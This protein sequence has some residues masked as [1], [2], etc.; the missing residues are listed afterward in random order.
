MNKKYKISS[1][2]M[3]TLIKNIYEL[4]KKLSG[5]ITVKN[6]DNAAEL[7]VNLFGYK[8]WKEFK[9]NLKKEVM[10]E[11][12]DQ[13]ENDL[14]Q[15]NYLPK[16]DKV[17]N[18]NNLSKYTFYPKKIENVEKKQSNKYS[19]EYL[20]GS[21]LIPNMKTKQPRGLMATDCI[22]TGNYNEEY[23]NFIEKHIEW[24]IE[25]QQDFIVFSKNYI[26][27]RKYPNNVVM[28]GKDHV[29]LNPLKAILNTDMFDS[30]F[31]I[32]NAPKSFS[33]LWSF[34]VKK[35]DMEDKNLSI[36]DLVN[37][38]DLEKLLS[39]KNECKNDF[40]LEKMLSQY[41]MQYVTD[42]ESNMV[43]TTESELRHYKENVYLI[44][45]LKKIK[46][47]YDEGYFSEDTDFN[48]K[49]S[50]FQKQS[51]IIKDFEDSVYHELIMSE[52]IIAHK[53]FQSDKQITENQHLLWVLVIEAESWIKKYQTQLFKNHLSFA[54]CFYIQ[55]NTQHVDDLFTS[56]N[57]ILFLKQS[58]TYKHSSWKD[59]MLNLTETSTV[60]FWYNDNLILKHLKPQEA[61]LWTIGDDPFA[62]NGLES[63]VL[64][65]I[66]LY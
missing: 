61:V 14:L 24:L 27:N 62:T 22:I 39:I 31:H 5:T 34:L 45:K 11:N 16:K 17:I 9:Q 47:L 35:F 13:L 32:E 10:L 6:L 29:R 56:V 50:I 20:I 8:N 38:T 44:N 54:H 55:N 1:D 28:V 51:C 42:N 59:K 64:E 15:P 33:Y 57:Q 30:F 7:A 3:K 40:V 52:Y 53:E 19:Q 41:L 63:F 18:N 60:N 65:K 25:N 4:S 12:L 23:Q 36:N 66:E 58:L 43:I 48:L 37:M 26:E 46:A 2:E 49:K 21:Y